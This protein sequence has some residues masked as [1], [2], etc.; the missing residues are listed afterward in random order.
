MRVERDAV[1]LRVEDDRA[2]AV[3]TDRVAG[4]EDLPAV[5]FHGGDR[6]VEPALA[7][8]VDQRSLL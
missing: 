7:A 3:G 6:F 8:E 4:L 5:R 1:P 2:E